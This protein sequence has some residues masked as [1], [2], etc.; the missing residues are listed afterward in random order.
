MIKV[1]LPYQI[2]YKGS[3]ILADSEFEADDSDKK[4]LVK[5]GGKIVG[6]GK[7]EQAKPTKKA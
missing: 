5:I 4:E 6:D 3:Y 2:K 1:I 7:S